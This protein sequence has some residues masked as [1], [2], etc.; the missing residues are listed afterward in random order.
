[1][2]F[3]KLQ[4]YYLRGTKEFTK[5]PFYINPEFITCIDRFKTDIE[6]ETSICLIEHYYEV[7]ETPE[8]ILNKIK[9]II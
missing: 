7:K 6:E 3:I 8:E 5:T 9:D 4:G 1:M 2:K